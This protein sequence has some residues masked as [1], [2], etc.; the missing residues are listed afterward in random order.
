MPRNPE[1]TPESDKLSVLEILAS[2][3]A[4]LA[5][6]SHLTPVWDVPS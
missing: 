4:R 5:E 1:V 6:L 2:L 3:V